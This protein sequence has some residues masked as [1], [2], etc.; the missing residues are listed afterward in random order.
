M[1]KIALCFW[2]V[3]RALNLTYKSINQNIY[4][5]LRDEGHEY[6][7]FMHVNKV[8][9]IKGYR[10]SGEDYVSVDFNQYK[11]L[12]PD[13]FA[14]DDQ[15]VVIGQIDMSRYKTKPDPW[16]NNYKSVELFVLSM[17]SKARVTQMMMN[18][19]TTYDCVIFLRPDMLYID[20]FPV[21]V[22]NQ[23]NDSNCF[24]PG[25]HTYT[26]HKHTSKVNDRFSVSNMRVAEIIGNSYHT[27]HNYCDNHA[28]H[29]ESFLSYNLYS[30]GIEVSPVHDFKFIR[31]RADGKIPVHDLKHVNLNKLIELEYKIYKYSEGDG[32]LIHIHEQE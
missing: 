14:Y 12:N 4:N 30:N 22:L 13:Q 9:Q 10:A 31:I 24:L 20:R 32:K 26:R 6:D 5:V 1:K 23:I 19:K 15:D 16:N 17:Y 18:A 27:L 28:C 3:T 8:D 21:D 2:G 25:F 7:V 11:L 29:S